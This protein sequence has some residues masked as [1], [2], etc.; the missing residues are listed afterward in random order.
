MDREVNVSS[1]GAPYEYTVTQK[2]TSALLFKKMTLIAF[3]VLWAALFLL[4]GVT[5]RLLVPFL[6]LIPLSIWFL[7]FLTWR[8][9]QVEYEYSFF[10]GELT[11]CR[12]LGGRS[13]RELCCVTLRSLSA[14]LPFDDY[15]ARRI[16]Q[17]SADKVIFA[18]SDES[19]EDL[20]A[21]MWSDEDG[22]KMLLF[23][24]PNERAIKI[25]R[26]YNASAVTL[27]KR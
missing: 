2:K 6:A 27:K 14:M 4:L 13:R 10:S 23:F 7:V 9:T 16:E 26:Y 17:Y 3:Y 8:Y 21:A 22:K 11:V 1:G 19:A 25:V 5:T 18:A 20:Y 12:V 24:E 15:G